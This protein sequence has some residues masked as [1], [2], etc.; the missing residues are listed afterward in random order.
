MKTCNHHHNE[1]NHGAAMD[2]RDF[3][4][5]GAAGVAAGAAAA[6]V[7]V[8]A[9]HADAAELAAYADPANP[10]LRRAAPRSSSSIRRS[11]S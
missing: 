2:R 1:G 5:L 4:N 11:T 6:T 9:S 7:G 3:L 10:A 8:A